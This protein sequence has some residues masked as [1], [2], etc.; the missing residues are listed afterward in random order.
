MRSDG[1]IDDVFLSLIGSKLNLAA[2]EW[3]QARA[4]LIR[5][6]G[7]QNQLS[8]I[9][10]Q[11]PRFA[12]RELLGNEHE[13]IDAVLAAVPG[14]NI[15]DWTV[16]TL[17]RVWLLTQVPW[18]NKAAYLEIVDSLFTG[19]EL[20]ELVALYK[21]LPLLRF[22]ERWISRCEEGIR[23]NMGPV[24]Q[25]IMYHNPYPASHLLE[26]AWNQMILKAIFTDKDVNQVFGLKKRLNP[27]LSA[28]L[29]DYVQE[30]LAAGRTVNPEIYKLIAD[31]V[32]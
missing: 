2:Y 10:A 18:D 6:T 1:L 4:A 21:A 7:S 19:A 29:A 3:L 16:E 11:I 27:A 28:T 8:M 12:S 30:R 13:A 25:A 20:N 9:F 31:K 15:S 17:C 23:S 22:P 14:Y 5:E 26:A 24:L 32:Y